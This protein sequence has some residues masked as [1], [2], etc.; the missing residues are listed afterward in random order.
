MVMMAADHCFYVE[1]SCFG[2]LI[3]NEN[4]SQEPI[5]IS[6]TRLGATATF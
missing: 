1:L 5:Q 2:N 4:G 6:L 3:V